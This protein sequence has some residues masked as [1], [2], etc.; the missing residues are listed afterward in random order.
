MLKRAIVIGASSGIGA[1]LVSKL[2][3]EGYRVAAV[4]RRETELQTLCA[5]INTKGE[6]PRAY[7]FPHD[8]KNTDETPTLFEKI[9]STLDGLDLVVYAAGVM[10]P[11]GEQEYNT[12]TDTEILHVN[13]LGAVSWLNLAAEHFCTQRGGT[14]VGIGSVAGDRGR[15]GNPGYCTSKA[16][17]HTFLESLRNRLTQHGVNVVTIKPGPVRTPMTEGLDKM[18]LAIEASEAAD[19][20]FR[21]I[22]RPATTAYVPFVWAPIMA[23]I[24][25]IPSV[26]FRRMDI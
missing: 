3:S 24:R 10:P 26:L 1:S 18:P 16:A 8:V 23:A 5:E 6:I 13:L 12:A 2:T 19:S 17:L 25:A 4:A 22:A 15:R 9:V 7:P 14:I 20:I 21:A 11:I